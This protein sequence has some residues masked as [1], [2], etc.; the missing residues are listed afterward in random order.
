MNYW[1][2][3]V[4][5]LTPSIALTLNARALSF[6]SYLHLCE[7]FSQAFRRVKDCRN[8]EDWKYEFGELLN[9]TENACHI[10]RSMI[11]LGSTRRLLRDYLVDLISGINDLGKTRRAAVNALTSD[12]TF[13]EIGTFAKRQN[14]KFL[15]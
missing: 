10:Y 9:L 8:D 4:G 7:D 11:V 13:T 2:W 6:S 14:I 15:E 12:R 1:L 5:V 3:L